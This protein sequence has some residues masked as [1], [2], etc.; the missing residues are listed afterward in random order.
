MPMQ[1]LVLEMGLPQH[2]LNQQWSELS[3]GQAQR[4][5]LSVCAALRP[6]VLLLD[7][8]TSACDRVSAQKWVAVLSSHTV[9]QKTV[10]R[11]QNQ[12]GQDVLG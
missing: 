12:P 1:A 11:H 2:V 5:M 8:P 4:A 9:Q 6:D 3:G 7:E 10:L